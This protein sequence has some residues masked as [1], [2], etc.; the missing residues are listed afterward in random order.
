MQRQ[1]E[2]TEDQVPLVRALGMDREI[3][4]NISSCM[5]SISF[6]ILLDIFSYF[7]LMTCMLVGFMFVF[8]CLLGFLIFHVMKCFDISY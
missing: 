8:G 1:D 4:L 3:S 6:C 2:I 7:P 5:H